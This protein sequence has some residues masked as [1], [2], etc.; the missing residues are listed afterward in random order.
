MP[1][2][3]AE[4]H[5]PRLAARLTVL[6]ERR[7]IHVRLRRLPKLRPLRGPRIPWFFVLGGFVGLAALLYYWVGLTVFRSLA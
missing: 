2:P 6:R 1:I 3:I 4:R 5:W 7:E